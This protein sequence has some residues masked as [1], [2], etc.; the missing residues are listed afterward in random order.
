[1]PG[2]DAGRWK[3]QKTARPC[4]GSR[5]VSPIAP[6]VGPSPAS[7]IE[8]APGVERIASVAAIRCASTNTAQGLPKQ[9]LVDLTRVDLDGDTFLSG[10]KLAQALVERRD[11]RRML[12]DVYYVAALPPL[13]SGQHSLVAH[14]R[15]R[16]TEA[17]SRR[18]VVFTD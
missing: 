1:M 14:L 12:S 17:E 7:R 16:G 15:V 9:P 2:A 13:T 6:G 11:R 8:R 3:A 5:K 18:E 4:R 10:D